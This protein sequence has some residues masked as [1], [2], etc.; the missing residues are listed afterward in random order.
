MVCMGTETAMHT[1]EMAPCRTVRLVHVTTF[2]TRP[3]GVCRMDFQIDA[4]TGFRLVLQHRHETTPALAEYRAVRL[5]LRLD[6]PA[7]V[8]LRPFGGFRQPL[9]VQVFNNNHCVVLA[10]CR[11]SLVVEIL[12]D[13]GQLAVFLGNLLFQ[14]FPVMGGFPGFPKVMRYFG[15]D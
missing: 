9:D 2:W 12:P 3:A 7:R 11:R 8:F 6:V 1:L 4:A 15:S 13:Q 5:A 10:Q 14:F